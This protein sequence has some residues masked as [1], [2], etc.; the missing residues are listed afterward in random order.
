[1]LKTHSF[2]IPVMGIGFTI[3][4]PL[5][6]SRFGIDSVI[7]LV[8]D[9][10]LEK[11]RKMYSLKFKIPYD[12][13]TEKMDDFRAER[14]TSYLNLIKSLSEEKFEEFKK[15]ITQTKQDI[16]DF[17][18]DLPDSSSLKQE[19]VKVT[20]S[21][22]DVKKVTDWLK[23]NLS[24]GQ[25]D[26]NIMTK[27]DKDN[28]TK[29]DKLA[30]EYND[31]HASLRG[32]AKSDVNS[33]VVFSAGM[34]PWLYAYLEGFKGFYPDENGRINKK[35]I[36]K[37][38]DYRSALIQGKFL[39]KKGI[40]VS[41][42]RIESGLN[43]GGHAFA[44]D[45]YLLGPVLEEF[46]IKRAELQESIQSLLFSAL[47]KKEYVVPETDLT[48]KISAQG[49][50]GTA[51][52]HQFLLNHYNIDSVGWGT[53]FLL[54]PEAT[55]VDKNTLNKLIKATEKDVYLS[56]ISPLGVPFYNLKGNTKDLEKQ[57]F[58]DKGRPG[59]ACPK[60]FIA[61]NKEFNEKGVCTA[62]RQFQHLKIK[63]LTAKNLSKE[64]YYKEYSKI[65][66]KSCTCVG[67][68]TSA[69]L[70]Y[71]LDTKTEGAGV[72]ICPSPNIAYFSKKMSLKEITKTIYGQSASV[73]SLERPNLFIKELTIYIDY[74]KDK[75]KETPADASP[76]EIK[77]L[78]TFVKNLKEGLLYYKNL[79]NTEYQSAILHYPAVL[80]DLELS[81]QNIN[82]VALAIEKL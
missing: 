66:A 81:S 26:V 47:D 45:G 8:D 78:K 46:K 73:T 60:K 38:S 6:V 39:A 4:S 65:I 56:D 24:M 71:G 68:G 43:C 50:V 29:T 54:V 2:H 48:F 27:V 13:I 28:Y 32:F 75:L 76:K 63:E 61:L 20:S 69:L 62:S 64:A 19:F 74:L 18:E 49:G 21:N 7:S 53:P 15:N 59:S 5:K 22:F 31:A 12:E 9:I 77:Y 1:M 3:D 14:V 42:Y 55:T 58:I 25:I 52:E 82:K 72:S 30:I 35:I 33:S 11:I 16:V 57:S 36:L 80:A 41:E 37:V 10:L 34:N 79:F 17:F 51:D 44:T 67:L 70:A 23:E 40:W